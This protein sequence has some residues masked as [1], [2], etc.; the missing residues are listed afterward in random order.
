MTLQ[1]H[2]DDGKCKNCAVGC[3]LLTALQGL[4]G[5]QLEWWPSGQGSGIGSISGL[6]TSTCL[7]LGQKK[8]RKKKERR[9]C[10][11]RLTD[12]QVKAGQESQEA[13]RCAKAHD[14]SRNLLG[15]LYLSFF[16]TQSQLDEKF[17]FLLNFLVVRIL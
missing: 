17:L 4:K 16:Q 12:H 8:K 11:L 1:R 14:Q 7:R 9:P 13:S 15:N 3:F 6:G 2:E 5:E 10:R